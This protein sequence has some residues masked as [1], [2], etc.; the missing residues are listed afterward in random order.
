M[1]VIEVAENAPEEYVSQA[2]ALSSFT[3]KGKGRE[4]VK[5]VD[6]AELLKLEGF[7]VKHIR[8]ET[9]E[10]KTEDKP[11]RTS[12]ILIEMEKQ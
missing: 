6:V 11:R 8:I 3:L 9:E 5:A 1:S 12:V 4:T 2:K 7:K 10:E